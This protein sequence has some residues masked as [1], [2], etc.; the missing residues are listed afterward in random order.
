MAFKVRG[1]AT[2][3]SFLS[4]S[5]L[6]I[7]PFLCPFYFISLLSLFCLSFVSPFS[8]SFLSLFC[9][10][11]LC[12]PFLSPVSFLSLS[13]FCCLRQ[14][15]SSLCLCLSV[16]LRFAWYYVSPRLLLMSLA[17]ACLL[18]CLALSLVILWPSRSPVSLYLSLSLLVV[19]SVV[20][21]HRQSQRGEVVYCLCL[22][23]SLLVSLS[24]SF[25]VSFCLF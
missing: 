16:C 5:F 24:V 9:V 23:L 10:S 4:L 3:A 20:E 14:L 18:V 21:M 6:F 7:V 1:D 25:S 19:V 13:L 11:L 22:F 2:G 8:V 15:A 12:L 17:S